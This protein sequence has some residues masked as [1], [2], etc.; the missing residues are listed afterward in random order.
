MKIDVT[1]IL[2]G[3]TSKLAIDYTDDTAASPVIG[4]LLPPD[5]LIPEGGVRVCGSVNDTGGYMSLSVQVT[6]DYTVP[7]DRCLEVTPFRLDFTLE[8]V[9]SASSSPEARER[10]ITEDEE[11]WDG[12]T[13]DLIYVSNGTIDFT[14]DLAEAISLELPMRHLCSEDCRGLC[15]V[16][17][18]KLS[19]EHPGCEIKKEIDPRL[20]ILQK[21]LD[22]SENM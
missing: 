5:V 11:E 8:R 9:V 7:C 10:L 3:R 12:V 14:Y 1:D 2:N 6:V 13:D 17:G 15:P 21:L 4:E 20:A 19:D 22:N 16:C 18:K